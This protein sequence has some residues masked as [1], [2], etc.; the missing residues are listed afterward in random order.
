M[1]VAIQ[2]GTGAWGSR[3]DMQHA[4]CNLPMHPSDIH[5]LAFS[6]NGNIYINTSLPFGAASSCAIFEKVTTALQW[7]VT[8]QTGCTWISHFLD[9]F[10]QQERSK[11][12]L[13]KF[14][15]QFQDILTDIGVPIAENKTL[16]PT[17]QLE[18]LGLMLDF[19]LQVIKIPEVKRI[20][21]LNLLDQ[22]LQAKQEKRNVTVKRV[23]QLAGS[24]NFICQALPAGRPF[25]ASLYRMTRS[26]T[27][28]KLKV[29]NHMRISDETRDDMQLFQSFIQNNAHLSVQTIPFLHRLDLHSKEIQLFAD[30]AGAADK[31]M[32]CVYQD[33]WFYGPWVQTNLFEGDFTPNIALLELLAIVTAFD[34]WAPD[35]QGKS[36]LLRSDNMVTCHMINKS[37]AEIP[38]AM[39]LIRHLTLSC[40]QF[41]IVVKCRHIK[42]IQNT[43][44]DL[45]SCNKLVEFFWLNPSVSKSPAMAPKSWPPE[46]SQ[47]Q[48]MAYRSKKLQ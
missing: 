32:G 3:I 39:A 43:N 8:E 6:L 28:V 18:Y 46:W 17:V 16:G 24:L 19:H 22:F 30:A 23:Q 35:L 33:Q 36:I 20:K 29:G 26:T 5:L 21:C 34:L 13:L 45:I 41:Q 25:L 7:I 37:K 14:M 42:G 40:L 11:H 2:I 27:G 15:S 48:M 1:A 9:D 47:D 12:Q 44:A 38:A 4:F 10:P 31:G